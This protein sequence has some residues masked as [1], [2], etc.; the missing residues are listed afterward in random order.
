LGAENKFKGVKRNGPE[1]KKKEK[2]KEK[3]LGLT[4]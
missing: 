3:S 1:K 4:H 2:I